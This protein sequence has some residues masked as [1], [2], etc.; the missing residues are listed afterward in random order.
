MSQTKNYVV[1][2][3][4]EMI[5][6]KLDIDLVIPRLTPEKNWSVRNAQIYALYVSRELP[7]FFLRPL[8][9]M[10]HDALVKKGIDPSGGVKVGDKSHSPRPRVHLKR[11]YIQKHFVEGKCKIPVD[12]L[13]IRWKERGITLQ[14]WKRNARIYVFKNFFLDENP[15]NFMYNILKTL[16][17]PKYVTI[18]AIRTNNIRN[19]EW[20]VR[21][22]QKNEVRGWWT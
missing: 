16:E 22:I 4:Y 17:Y 12:T 15:E 10:F 2:K 11:Y 14:Y 13:V 9:K 7:T 19:L 18:D 8:K 5:T 20:I 1:Q 3:K 21:T 6:K